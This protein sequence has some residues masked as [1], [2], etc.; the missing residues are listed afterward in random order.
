MRNWQLMA[1]CVCGVALTS[2]ALGS[3]NEYVRYHE[4]CELDSEAEL[5]P[6]LP[7]GCE[8]VD[9]ALG[10]SG[11]SQLRVQI[12]FNAPEGVT[13]AL[14][15]TNAS[16]QSPQRKLKPGD[17]V[18][19]GFV[20]GADPS[21]L[22]TATVVVPREILTRTGTSVRPSAS[23]NVRLEFNQFVGELLVRQDIVTHVYRSC[24]K[25]GQL[26]SQ[27]DDQLKL[28]NPPD[29]DA[30]AL[31]DGRRSGDCP[32][33]EADFGKTT[34]S[35]GNLISNNAACPA[36]SRATI[37]AHD[38]AVA[39]VSSIPW[40]GGS[41]TH[42]VALTQPVNEK[43][44]VWLLYDPC[45]SP[46]GADDCQCSSTP[47]QPNPCTAAGRREFPM[48]MVEKA[49][50]RYA[51]HFSGVTF[52]TDFR[53]LSQIASLGP[54]LQSKVQAALDVE[55]CDS[56][57][58][59]TATQQTLAELNAVRNAAGVSS[60]P[61]LDVFFVYTANAIGWW[62]GPDAT[63]DPSP[64]PGLTLRGADTLVLN[65][66]YGPRTL[67]HEIG[68]SLLH[69]GVHT[70]KPND[71]F[72]TENLMRAGDPGSKLT[73]GQ[74]FAMNIGANSAINRHGARTGATVQCASSPSCAAWSLT[75][76]CPAA[77]FEPP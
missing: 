14:E 56:T 40:T 45:Y 33:N 74:V 18:I 68:H 10:C 12:R 9:P 4:I 22:M 23:V 35:V 25:P 61:H 31:I 36:P 42:T 71:G 34:I 64:Q 77:V 8:I 46:S 60:E 11:D 26:L 53:D 49:I 16:G 47:T 39:F 20:G 65:A 30:I 37:F 21:P 57:S 27:H 32:Q 38:R 48:L 1:S 59:A 51:A 5:P 13:A 58:G 73:R 29:V 66:S 7:I 15:I 44:T 55:G 76:E 24:Q 70:N 75:K 62:C 69:C 50:E 72:T 17:T 28:Q 52:Q 63:N 19:S 41:D 54:T 43:M 3:R 6:T 67:A 2:T